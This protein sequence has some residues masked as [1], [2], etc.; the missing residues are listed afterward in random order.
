MHARL[1]IAAIQATQAGLRS[2]RVQG[3]FAA[4]GARCHATYDILRAQSPGTSISTRCQWR[5]A[6]PT[7][8]KMFS[9]STEEI[10]PHGG[11]ERLPP[12]SPEEAMQITI[13]DR[14]G[15]RHKVDCKVGDNILYLCKVLHEKNEALFLEGACEAS[16]ACSTCHVIIEEEEMFNKLPPASDE[17]EDMLDQAAC[18]TSTS[19]LG[20]QLKLTKDLDGMTIVLP[21]FSRNFYVDGHVPEGH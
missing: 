18:L 7:H 15:V 17:E 9:T 11:Y 12:K 14:K 6:Q 2:G 16:L 10:E 4:I 3:L 21:K 1:R 20:C 5:I 19:R 8:A 13:V